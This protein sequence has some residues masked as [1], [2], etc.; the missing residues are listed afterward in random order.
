MWH[1]FVWNGKAMRWVLVSTPD[2]VCLVKQDDFCVRCFELKTRKF[3]LANEPL[4]DDERRAWLDLARQKAI[5]AYG[6]VG[7]VCWRR[8]DK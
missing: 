5:K 7:C 4:K 6:A 8:R 2:D 3:V 1:F